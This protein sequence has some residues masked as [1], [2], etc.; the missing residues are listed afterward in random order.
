MISLYTVKSMSYCKWIRKMC[1]YKSL[2]L[3]LNECVLDKVNVEK[4]LLSHFIFAELQCQNRA[5]GE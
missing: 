4:W 1:N 2:L 5:H 3:L